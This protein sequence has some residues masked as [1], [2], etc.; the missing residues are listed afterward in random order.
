MIK[1]AVPDIEEEEIDAMV[2]VMRS[3]WL[4]NGPIVSEF[5]EDL[6]KFTGY[7]YAV[8]VN[9]ATMASSII[10]DWLASRKLLTSVILPNLTFA[11]PA[12][13]AIR[14]GINVFVRDVDD[15]TLCMTQPNEHVSKTTWMMPTDYAGYVSPYVIQ[16]GGMIRDGAAYLGP[17]DGITDFAVVS[18]YANKVIT[19]AGEGGA[20]LTNNPDLAEYAKQARLHGI[21]KDAHGR[22]S[23]GVIELGYDVP[24]LG[25]KANM[26]DVSAACGVMQL[27]SAPLMIEARR[28]LAD[29]Y[30]MQLKDQPIRLPVD[31]PN[32]PYCMY[33][34]RFETETVRDR[35][36]D[37]LAAEQIGCSMHY[38]LLTELTALKGK[39]TLSEKTPVAEN[40]RE[41]ML[42]LPMHPK[43]KLVEVDRVCDVIKS[44]LNS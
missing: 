16:G 36:R 27:E 3:G 13:Q 29:H 43:L 23:R 42:S 20:I 37:A 5:E 14:R 30:R 25:Q 7:T 31:Q 2:A 24:I 28:N 19:T 4:T 44:A 41:T 38:P 1:L 17:R 34:V 9:S 21:S 32:H 39:L 33:V 35:V 15:D 18:F 40:A 10:F 12:I 11:S 26:T 8:A 6:E 22:Q